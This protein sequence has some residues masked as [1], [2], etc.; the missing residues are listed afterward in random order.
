M[1]GGFEALPEVIRILINTA[2]LVERQRFI[3]AE[4]YQALQW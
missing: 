4:A 3:R 2:M 1:Q